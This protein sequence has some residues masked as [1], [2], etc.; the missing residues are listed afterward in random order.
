MWIPKSGYGFTVESELP[1][2]INREEVKLLQLRLTI[3]YSLQTLALWATMQILLVVRR[4]RFF[5]LYFFL[6]QLDSISSQVFCLHL[7]TIALWCNTKQHSWPGLIQHNS[8]V[9]IT[10]C[11]PP[12]ADYQGFYIY[13]LARN[14]LLI[15]IKAQDNLFNLR[16]TLARNTHK[17]CLWRG[18]ITAIVTLKNWSWIIVHNSVTVHQ[19]P[20]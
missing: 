10:I 2:S 1:T 5:L 14:D 3:R 15:K 6:S 4:T 17:K 13:Y 19:L 16:S 12:K 11:Y 7:Q 18:F 9:S 8:F 20:P